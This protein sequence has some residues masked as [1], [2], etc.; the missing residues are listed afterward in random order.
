M[1]VLRFALAVLVGVACAEQGVGNS[2]FDEHWSKA[3]FQQTCQ[4]PQEE[5]STKG[6]MMNDAD[7]KTL[8]DGFGLAANTPEQTNCM[9]NSQKN[10][11]AS[12]NM[13]QCMPLMAPGAF[14]NVSVEERRYG[15]RGQIPYEINGT[16]YGMCKDGMPCKEFNKFLVNGSLAALEKECGAPGISRL[17]VH[18]Y[19]LKTALEAAAMQA[20]STGHTD[21]CYTQVKEAG[22]SMSFR[23][24]V[25]GPIFYI[26]MVFAYA[27][28]G[29]DYVKKFP[30]CRVPCETPDCQDVPLKP[31]PEVLQI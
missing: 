28:G 27:L 3:S 11:L 9:L 22:K 20:S 14:G 4:S 16:H 24:P 18:P 23:G 31:I 7:F 13:K 10:K 2:H 17:L 8:I 29:E 12:D 15:S 21:Q 19:F 26:N 5:S 25:Y 6:E 1:P 30:G